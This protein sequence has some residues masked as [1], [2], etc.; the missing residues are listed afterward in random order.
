MDE[1]TSALDPS[2][3]EH[4]MNQLIEQLAEATVIS[5][6]HRLELERFHDR[7]I[8]LAYHPDGARLVPDGNLEWPRRPSARMLSR[9][10]ARDRQG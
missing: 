6:S 1:A 4:L 3:Q 9:V 5:V 7:R 2:S 10:L 8:L